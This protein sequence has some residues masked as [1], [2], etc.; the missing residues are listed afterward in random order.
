MVLNTADIRVLPGSSVLLS[1]QGASGFEDEEGNP[2]PDALVS[3]QNFTLSYDV[4][5][6]DG[7]PIVLLD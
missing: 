5:D 2:L 4:S 3:V 1:C 7:E 6:F